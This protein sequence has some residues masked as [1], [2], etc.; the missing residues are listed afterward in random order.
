MSGAFVTTLSFAQVRLGVANTT[1]AAIHSSVNAAG[2]TKAAT[3]AAARSTAGAR[4]TVTTTTTSGLSA[5]D[6]VKQ[7]T[8]VKGGARVNAQADVHASEQARAHA[9]ENSAIF[10]AKTDDQT[11]VDAGVK[12][13]VNGSNAVN[14]AEEKETKIKTK[15]ENTADGTITKTKEKTVETKAAA[16]ADV[17]EAKEDVKNTKA[18]ARLEAKAET[19]VKA[20]K[21]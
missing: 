14:A 5:A 2:V 1:H 11:R 21:H 10:G 8:D 7:N 9:N 17:K 19:S 3:G 6:K 13:H 12:A 18:Q 16:K 15:V 4:N 20:G